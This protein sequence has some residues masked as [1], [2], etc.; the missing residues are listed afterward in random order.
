MPRRRR[1]ARVRLELCETDAPPA[2]DEARYLGPFRTAAGARQARDLVRAIFQLDDARQRASSADYA[3]SLDDAWQFLGGDTEPGIETVRRRLALAHGARDFAA[4]RRW[5]RVLAD[6][7]AY[8]LAMLLLPAEPRRARYVVARPGP[9]G[10]EV[11][12]LDRGI[13]V[14]RRTFVAGEPILFAAALIAEA[15]PLTAPASVELVVRWMVSQRSTAR[16][17]LVPD[18]E[19]DA[20]LAVHQALAAVLDASADGGEPAS[21]GGEDLV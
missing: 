11:Y 18:D 15:R 9:L 10:V 13:L 6:A 14:G 20:M 8:A 21:S 16:V 19:T 3:R 7:S 12:L 1:R 17:L 4:Q 5:Q 2:D